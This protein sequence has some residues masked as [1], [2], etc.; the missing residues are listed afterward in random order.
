MSYRMAPQTVPHGQVFVLGDNR[1][2][3]LDSHVWGCLD[4]SLL[5]GRPIVRYWPPRRVRLLTARPAAGVA[6]CA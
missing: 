4:E 1:N 3:S 5:I 6:A 2:F